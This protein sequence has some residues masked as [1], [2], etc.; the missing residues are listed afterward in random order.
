[1]H[2]DWK[3]VQRTLIQTASGAGIALITAVAADYSKES[4]ITACIGFV[5]SVAI[6]VLMNI[7]KQADEYP[8]DSD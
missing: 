4:I 1:M 2:I 3:R 8:E 7:Q 6:A 5:T